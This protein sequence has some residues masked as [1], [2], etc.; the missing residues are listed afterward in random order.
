MYLYLLKA[1]FKQPISKLPLIFFN[2]IHDRKKEGGG[3]AEVFCSS[4]SN[5]PYLV[6]Y[7]T[8]ITGFV[9]HRFV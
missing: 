9:L 5:F 2:H 6:F 7:H 4:W 1:F 3:G 8:S